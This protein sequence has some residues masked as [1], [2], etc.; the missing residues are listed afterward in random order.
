MAGVQAREAA[1]E[2]AY[3]EGLAHLE[4]GRFQEAKASLEMAVAREPQHVEAYYSLGVACARLG[5]RDEAREQWET[6]RRLQPDHPYVRQELESLLPPRERRQLARER[7]KAEEEAQ[8]KK[9]A[10]SA[11][12]EG[13]ALLLEYEKQLAEKPA[14]EEEV[15]GLESFLYVLMVGIVT[16]V[17]YA[18]NP[19]AYGTRLVRENVP[20]MLELTGAIAAIVFFL[21]LILALVSRLLARIFRGSGSWSAYLACS[22]H[23][24][25]PF[26]L[27]ILPIV[28]YVPQIASRVPEK[29]R[30]F[31]ELSW[32]QLPPLPW[33]VFG[34][35]A[36]F[37]G[38]FSFLRGISRVGRIA[39]W[40][41]MLVGFLSVVLSLGAVGAA[42][43]G[44]LRWT[45]GRNLLEMLGIKQ[46]LARPTPT[47][48]TTPSPGTTPTP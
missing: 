4:A 5:L 24:L 8:R 44:I 14:P 15:G 29:I 13:Q 33:I 2:D 11:R 42:V 3:R 35:L 45:H 23:F 12:P 43:Y 48:G 19:Q 32:W 41:G 1:V 38:L 27:L 21:W 40:K 6:V 37:W 47:P 16:G 30:S 9:K 28:L 22:S 26:F 34:G 17:A 31:L 46:L 7:R 25:M 39:L 10:A 18:L 20:A 36:L